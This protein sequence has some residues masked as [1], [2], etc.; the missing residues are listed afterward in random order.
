MPCHQLLINFNDYGF[1][2]LFKNAKSTHEGAAPL[3][4]GFVFRDS[5]RPYPHR[6]IIP[7]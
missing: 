4:C 2:T 3:P 5:D 7:Y 6:Y 1:N